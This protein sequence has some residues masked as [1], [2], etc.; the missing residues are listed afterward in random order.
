MIKRK[1]GW[2]AERQI[3]TQIVA[4]YGGE[5]QDRLG[6]A[7]AWDGVVAR[8]WS[9]PFPVRWIKIR[10]YPSEFVAKEHDRLLQRYGCHVI[11]D[12]PSGNPASGVGSALC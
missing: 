10:E 4:D 3:L 2:P 1:V 7:L 12:T 5:P 8:A 11:A 6:I 9:S